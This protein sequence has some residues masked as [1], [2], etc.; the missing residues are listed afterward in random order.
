MINDPSG[1]RHRDLGKLQVGAVSENAAAG[2]LLLRIIF[3][4]FWLPVYLWRRRKRNREMS[5]LVGEMIHENPMVSA[6]DIALKWALSHRREYRFGD[7]DP[8]LP[9]LEQ[10]FTKTMDRLKR[11]RR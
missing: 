1:Q 3:F 2:A 6:K 5:V 10:R 7:L 9:K 8:K 11:D 4:P